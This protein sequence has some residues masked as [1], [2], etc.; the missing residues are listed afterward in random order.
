METRDN[1]LTRFERDGA[2]PLSTADASGFVA[3]GGA[4]IWYASYGSGPAVVLLHGGFG[5]G[6]NWGYQVPTLLER[7]YRA[8]LIDTR[9][10]GRSTREEGPFT[11]ELLAADVLAVMDALHLNTAAFV[12][13]SDGATT[14]LIVAMLQPERVDGVFFF[15]GNMDPSGVKEIPDSMPIID[16]IFGRHVQDYTRLSETPDRFGDFA[17]AVNRMMKTEP[18]YS[19]EQL[20]TIRV[21]VDVVLGEHDE[22]IKHEHA[23]YLANSIPNATLRILPEVS[24]FAPLQR[25]AA[26][27]AAMTHSLDAMHGRRAATRPA[28]LDDIT[29][30]IDLFTAVVDERTWLGTEPGFDRERIRAGYTRTI[31]LDDYLTLVAEVN[32]SIAGTLRLT[33]EP[34]V[35]ALG[36]FVA[37]DRRGH[38]TGTALVDAALQWARARAIPVIRLGVFAHNA[39]GLRLYEKTGFR[40]TARRAG[41]YVRQT[42]EAF[43]LLEMERRAG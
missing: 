11:Y 23:A 7:G 17:A 21:P 5:N 35:Y 10:H 38:G 3:H 13:W 40:I 14:A 34:D 12:G 36:M 43:D 28:R 27:N 19:P 29:A 32:G 39:A 15:G 18:N 2:A 26:F 33:P 8:V 22:F 1:D 42:G 24:H 37:A 4:R 25:P 30:L 31:V 9:G 20:A 41:A 6:E 16:R